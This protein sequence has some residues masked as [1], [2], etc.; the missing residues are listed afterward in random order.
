MIS[1]L[2]KDLNG[3][4]RF[5]TTSQ[6]EKLEKFIAENPEEKEQIIKKICKEFEIKPEH[7]H[8]YNLV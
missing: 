8:S 6:N 7:L 2:V 5:N 1:I 3:T 4:V